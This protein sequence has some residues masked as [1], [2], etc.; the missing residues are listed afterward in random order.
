MG[1]SAVPQFLVL[2]RKEVQQTGEMKSD[3]CPHESDM[4]RF[5]NIPEVFA[6]NQ[7]K[8]KDVL[9]L[10]PQQLHGGPT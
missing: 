5:D 6:T 8:E 1:L 4:D 9:D 7:D 2:R 10:Y 3:G